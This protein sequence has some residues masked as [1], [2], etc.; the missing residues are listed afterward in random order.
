MQTG[1]LGKY[2]QR[3][4]V[5][6]AGFAFLVLLIAWPMGW[7]QP[8]TIGIIFTSVGGSILAVSCFIL[9]SNV[10]LS[11]WASY[12]LSGARIMDAHPKVAKEATPSRPVF[13]I[14]AIVNRIILIL[15]G[16]LLQNM[17]G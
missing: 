16:Y 13:L 12:S 4:I 3:T 6:Q 2:F 9:L 1:N 5:F 10:I 15:I 11:S 14:L 7:L 17:R 8:L